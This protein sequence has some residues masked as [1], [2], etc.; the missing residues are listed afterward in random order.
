MNIRQPESIN[1]A[2]KAKQML[3]DKPV[4]ENERDKAM[5]LS[6]F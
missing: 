6:L 4:K 5:A 2:W 3:A 1:H